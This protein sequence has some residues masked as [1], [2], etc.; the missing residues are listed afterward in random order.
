MPTLARDGLLADLAAVLSTTLAAERFAWT[1]GTLT[2]ISLVPPVLAEADPAT[3]AVLVGLHLVA[4]AVVIP[5]L[6][7]SLRVRATA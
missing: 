7:R 1:A 2:A 5:T 6:T 4:A 3:T